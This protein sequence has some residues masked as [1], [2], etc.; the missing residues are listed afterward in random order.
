[1]EVFHVVLWGCG[2]VDATAGHL[3]SL[4][5]QTHGST[6]LVDAPAKKS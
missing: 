1:M 5:P 4:M 2:L 3:S 6:S